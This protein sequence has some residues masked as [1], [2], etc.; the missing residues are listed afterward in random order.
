ML[1]TTNTK[2]IVTQAIDSFGAYHRDLGRLGNKQQT[3]IV[4]PEC[5]MNK[6]RAILIGIEEYG[7]GLDPLPVVH[8]DVERMCAALEYC[9]YATEKVGVARQNADSLGQTLREFCEDCQS[10]DVFL[11]YFSGHGLSVDHKDFMVPS[12]VS[13]TDAST[14]A[15]SRVPTNLS[16]FASGG[17][18]IFVVDAC[19]N[20]QPLEKGSVDE[21]GYEAAGGPQFVRFLG[22]SSG[23][24]CQVVRNGDN[25]RDI[26]MFTKAMTDALAEGEHESLRKLL[27]RCTERCADLAGDGLRAQKPP[28]ELRRDNGGD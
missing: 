3:T 15:H 26:S 20:A 24:T 6:R 25:G 4:T 21:F 13:L 10:G 12:N 9:G 23:E 19:R 2:R 27:E 17:L 16:D 1:N 22:C 28:P 14:D 18:V 11:I 8:N 5:D 7:E